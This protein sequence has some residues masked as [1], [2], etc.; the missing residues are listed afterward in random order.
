MPPKITLIIAT[1]LES[2]GDTS[3]TDINLQ[4][5]TMGQLYKVVN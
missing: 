2:V 3:I 5:V 4:V 1:T